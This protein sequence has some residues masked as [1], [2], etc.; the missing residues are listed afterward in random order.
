LMVRMITDKQINSNGVLT[1]LGSWAV[2]NASIRCTIY[3]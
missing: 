3:R 2:N 1:P